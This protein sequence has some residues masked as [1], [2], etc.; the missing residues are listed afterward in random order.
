MALCAPVVVLAAIIFIALVQVVNL[1]KHE[2][3]MEGSARHK[4]SINSTDTFNNT[5][6]WIVTMH[7]WHDKKS[8]KSQGSQDW[9]LEKI[10]DKIG[11]T[12]KFFVEF[13][14][15]EPNYTAGASGANTR[16]LYDQGWRGLLLDGNN[17]NPSINLH[18]HYLF[19]SNIAN[20]FETYK[21]PKDLDY[22]S[23]DMDSHDLFVF[24]AI[25]QGGYRPRV[26]T[27]EYNSN[28]LLGMPIAQLDPEIIYGKLP[29]SYKFSFRCQMRTGRR[30]KT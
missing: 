29:A 4:N 1:Q 17:D 20:I 26:I 16:N 28:Y 9:Y 6:E 21:V 5:N 22:L 3:I 14:F 8:P 10:F 12:N 24:E 30:C 15:N 27:T 25:L 11:S 7:Q 2:F 19:A 18:A 23:C 13:G